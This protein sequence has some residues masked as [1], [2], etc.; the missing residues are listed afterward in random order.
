MEF[1]E[2]LQLLRRQKGI[3]Q[4]ELAEKL[5]V[6]RT[7][8]SKWESGRGYPNIESLKAIAKFF[9]VTLD[10]LLSTDEALTIAEDESKNRQKQFVSLSFG[11]IDVCAVL[12]L[13]L[14][15]FAQR[16]DGNVTETSLLALNGVATWLKVCYLI[17]VAAVA[18]FGVLMLVLQNC[19]NGIWVKT[20]LCLSLGLGTFALV[21]FVAGLQP[22]AA[23]FA[24][25]LLAVKTFL[26][27]KN[28]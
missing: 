13:F 27:I 3:T 14:P 9:G 24:L 19:D 4:E 28:R 25:V 17:S 2:K 15:F 22:Y 10:E 8:V 21:V 12:L 23:V 1:N 18:V 7:A 6:S 20:K 5:Y 11:L 16:T 26:F